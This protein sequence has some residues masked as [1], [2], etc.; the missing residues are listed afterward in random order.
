MKVR[1][2]I[3][4]AVI[5]GVSVAVMVSGRPILWLVPVVIGAVY[6]FDHIIKRSVK[7]K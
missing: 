7:R 3:E 4:G 6:G 5:A 1:R 2:L